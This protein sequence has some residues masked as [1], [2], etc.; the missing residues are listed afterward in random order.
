MSC[1]HVDILAVAILL[2]GMALLSSAR[3]APF[4]AIA[5]KRIA[6]E[7]LHRPSIAIPKPPRMPLAFD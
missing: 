3:Y 2:L 4:V 1:K 6:A 7:R 5:Q